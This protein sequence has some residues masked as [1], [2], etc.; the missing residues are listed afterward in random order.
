[1]RKIKDFQ[2]FKLSSLKMRKSWLMLLV[3]VLISLMFVYGQ[4]I[5]VIQCNY[6]G[7]DCTSIVNVS[8][9]NWQIIDK[10]NKL[11][12]NF[13]ESLRNGDKILI[14]IT[15]AIT[16][17]VN[18]TV[19]DFDTSCNFPNYGWVYI[20]NQE[21]LYNITLNLTTPISELSISSP[22][23]QIKGIDQI[24]AIRS[25]S[26][27]PNL[28]IVSPL[29][30]TYPNSTIL[31]NLA[32]ED[33]NLDSVWW[34]NGTDNVSYVEGY[35]E[36]A[37]GSNIIL[38]YANDTAGNINDTESVTFYVD[39]LAPDLKIVLPEAKTYGYNES[40]PLNF[41]VEDENLDSCWFYI[42]NSTND[43]INISGGSGAVT[44]NTTIGINGNCEN[45]TF[46]VSRDDSY[47]L[48]LFANDSLG[49]ESFDFVGFSVFTSGPAINLIYPEN[50]SYL[51][52]AGDIYFNYSVSSGISLSSC[53]L[54]GDLGGEW[55]LNQTNNSIIQGDNFFILNYL[56]DSD[57]KWGIVC[58][59]SENNVNNINFT[60]TIDTI[61]PSLSLSEPSGEKISQSNIPLQF[62]VS[63]EN[64]DSC[65]YNLTRWDGANWVSYRDNTDL[66]CSNT[67][68]TFNV[69]DDYDYQIYLSV[70]D[71]AGFSNF[72]NSS[73]SIASDDGNGGNG[74]NGGG[75]GSSSVGPGRSVIGKIEIS[76]LENIIMHPGE[77]KTLSINVKNPG[78]RY[79]NKCKL[80]GGGEAADWISG[81]SIGGIAGGQAIDVV[82]SIKAP[83]DVDRDVGATIFVECNETKSSESFVI[84]V[85][86][87]G[88]K[89]SFG[90][91]EQVGK[92]L[93]FS[94]VI[95]NI[96]AE[97]LNIDVEYWL[98]D[99]NNN[100]D[101]ENMDSFVL[102]TGESVKKEG[103]L[104]LEGLVAGTYILVMRAGSEKETVTTQEQVLISQRGL[105][106]AAIFGPEG[107][108]VFSI[109]LL[110]GA[111]GVIGFFVIR[112]IVRNVGKKDRAHFVRHKLNK[113]RKHR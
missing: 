70:N 102:N 113:R 38:V 109:I 69:V 50:N 76:G 106:G 81:S 6:K 96:E 84:S 52:Y 100:K 62:S 77:S 57:Y 79:L 10:G 88:L 87:S 105:T 19:C 99:E 29:N 26:T 21:G 14:N 40:L 4:N 23:E 104:S 54:W 24:Y 67:S 16:K 9:G 82:F 86:S 95:E 72:T 43:M 83:K 45:T 112:R 13:S 108:K 56:L 103:E 35:Y 49:L 93:R 65:W 48:Y 73:F 85:L 80:S 37:Q 1:M 44:E 5:D 78:F 64:L 107:G 12:L 51:N 31:V 111:A 27:A 42:L 28:T 90:E 7:N 15:S 33:E 46:N 2:A 110:I 36:F 58:N 66:N 34:Y 11:N 8:D 60:F 63:D 3:V 101:V 74:G 30:R 89:L 53:E 32:A 55:H 97:N 71:S 20:P 59:D 68:I 25:D 18:L 91:I 22:I 47:T 94:Y 39:S 17:F 98:A 75:G 61:A 92:V 41:T